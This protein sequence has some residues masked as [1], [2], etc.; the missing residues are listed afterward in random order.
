VNV[1][2]QKLLR[3]LVSGDIYCVTDEK[4]MRGYDYICGHGISL[5]IAKQLSS[6]RAFTQALGRV[7]RYGDDKC[8][9]FV[10]IAL[11][12]VGSVN[13]DGRKSILEAME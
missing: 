1:T 9:R 12:Q 5:M 3:K 7:G 2:D 11:E 10:D 6:D 13:K 8:I 4:K